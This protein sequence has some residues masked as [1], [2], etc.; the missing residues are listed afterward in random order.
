VSPAIRR[1]LEEVIGLAGAYRKRREQISRREKHSRARWD[2]LAAVGPG[3]TVPSI[4]R[5]IGL[6]RQSVQRIADLLAEARLARFEANPDHRR[7]PLLRP[8]DE[9]LRLRE[10]LERQLH[11]WELTVEELVDAEDLDTALGV[12]QAIRSGLER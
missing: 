4:A 8:T 12:L 3:R 9:G 10:R 7:S 5:Q 11:G 6:S 2:V 1:L